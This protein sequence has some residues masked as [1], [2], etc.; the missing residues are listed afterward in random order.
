MSAG[1]FRSGTRERP[2]ALLSSLAS[3][4]PSLSGSGS[5]E[6][7]MMIAV[8][9]RH[10]PDEQLR[11]RRL[12]DVHRHLVPCD[13]PPSLSLAALRHQR[14]CAGDASVHVSSLDGGP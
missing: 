11:P 5:L 2:A 10:S 3:I 7:S 1:Y 14:S 8:F 4:V 13:Q 6:A 9:N 12:H